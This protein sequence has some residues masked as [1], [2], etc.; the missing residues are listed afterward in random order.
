[1]GVRTT[2]VAVSLASVTAVA[3]LAA[4]VSGTW[5]SEFDTQIGPQKYVFTFAE[6]DGA[7]TATARASVAGQ[8]DRDVKFQDLKLE[9]D[10]ISFF[11]TFSFQG[12][13]IRIDYSGKVTA[14]EMKLTRK[15]GS[16]A[17]EHIVVK[18]VAETR[19]PK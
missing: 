14:D 6:R 16:F 9:G 19:A 2:I 5:K 17:E 7:L 10:A 13:D 8:P 1:M 18:R 15:V 11:E 3:A 12:M 4:D